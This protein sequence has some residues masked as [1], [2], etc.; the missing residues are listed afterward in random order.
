MRRQISQFDIDKER[1]VTLALAEFLNNNSWEVVACH[2]PGGHTSF[3]ILNG[4]RSKGG[5]MPDVVAI[6]FDKNI[7]D[8]IVIVA[9][10]KP[11][12]KQANK[13]IQKLFK[14]SDVHAHWIA[15]RLQKHINAKKWL[16]NWR[17]KLQKI[18]AFA[19]GDIHKKIIPDN[20]IAIKFSSNKLPEITF[21]EKAPARNLLVNQR[22]TKK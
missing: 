1:N 20:V 21:G 5:Y 18:I 9:E 15:F 2:P 11:T 7:N 8:F 6:K 19:E 22:F 17:N 12:F 10:S 3:S 13:D 16:N 4:R 14:L